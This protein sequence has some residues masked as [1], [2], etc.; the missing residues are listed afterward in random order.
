MEGTINVRAWVTDGQDVCNHQQ[1][2]LTGHVD[3]LGVALLNFWDN[4][5]GAAGITRLV[6]RE[7]GFLV[8]TAG[9]RGKVCVQ[10]VGER[11]PRWIAC[12]FLKNVV[13]SR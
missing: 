4:H 10:V 2:T 5:Y 1:E 6:E 8:G 11:V 13:N 9:N 7:E 12:E 3:N